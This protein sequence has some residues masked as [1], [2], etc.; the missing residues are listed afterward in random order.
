MISMRPPTQVASPRDFL[1][2][3]PRIVANILA[4]AMKRFFIADDVFEIVA[5]PKP[6]FKPAPVKLFDTVDITLRRKRFESM[7]DICQ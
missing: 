4:D 5:L 6:T 1:D 7:D 2:R 3:I